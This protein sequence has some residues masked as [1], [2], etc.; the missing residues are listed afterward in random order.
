MHP[1]IKLS[2]R[3]IIIIKHNTQLTGS[4]LILLA[5]LQRLHRE[6]VV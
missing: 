6:A 4:Y 3:Q 1:G 5:A 2:E